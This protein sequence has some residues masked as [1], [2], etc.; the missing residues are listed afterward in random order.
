MTKN[1]N[2]EANQALPDADYW[3]STL[4]G[5]GMDRMMNHC[6]TS[7]ATAWCHQFGVAGAEG[8]MAS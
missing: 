7:F 3:M 6:P 1:Q 4:F 2:P 8:A 5:R